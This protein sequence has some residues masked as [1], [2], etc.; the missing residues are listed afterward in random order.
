MRW[1]DIQ[2]QNIHFQIDTNNPIYNTF[3]NIEEFSHEYYTG[4]DFNMISTKLSDTLYF[5]SEFLKDKKTEIPFEINFY[6]TQSDNGISIFGL[7]KSELLIGNDVWIINP[8]DDPLHKLSYSAKTKEIKL[9][10]F[11]AVSGNQTIR[12]SGRHRNKN[13]FVLIFNN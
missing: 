3:L 13:D 7:K 9:S 4:S 1:K 12:F 10:D 6:N 11:N 8:L 2:F 5:R